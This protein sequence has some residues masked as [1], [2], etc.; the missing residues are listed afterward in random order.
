[1]ADKFMAR[2]FHN[3]TF[4]RSFPLNSMNNLSFEVQFSEPVA[5]I[6]FF[7]KLTIMELVKLSYINFDTYFSVFF[8]SINPVLI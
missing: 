1:M 2:Y 7:D 3:C 6:Y 8:L 5:K 4:L